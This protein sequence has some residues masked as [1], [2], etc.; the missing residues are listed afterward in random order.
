MIHSNRLARPLRLLI[1]TH[2][3][4]F[5]PDERANAGV[6]I[7]DVATALQQRGHQVT[8]LAPAAPQRVQKP[9]AVPV[10]RFAWWG[11]QEA[12]GSWGLNPL[13]IAR[14]GSFLY[15]GA[16]AA[17]RLM[18]KNNF[19]VILSC[20]V[21]PGGVLA[22][23]AARAHPT[24]FVTWSLGTDIYQAARKPLLGSVIR[25]ILADASARFADGID[26]AHQTAL[27]GGKECRFLPSASALGGATGTERAKA[28]TP[29]RLVFVGRLE[30][31]KGPD[32][33]IEGL[34]QLKPVHRAQITLTLVGDGSL[35]DELRRRIKNAHLTKTVRMHGNESNPLVLQALL[36]R[37]DWLLIPSRSDSIPLVF[38]EA[39]R[40]NLPIAAA[41][42]GDL[43]HLVTTYK[44]GVHFAPQNPDAIAAALREM[45]ALPMEQYRR[46]CQNTRRAARDFSLERTVVQLEKELIWCLKKNKV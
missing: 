15:F 34:A 42:V 24:P 13:A 26:L 8:I 33:L 43:K 28:H 16:R 17:R 44:V 36:R 21:F 31:V 6:F 29:L 27:L 22:R 20:W 2:N 10:V 30:P 46:L 37:A 11:A 3:V 23:S 19:D 41:E 7:A 5:S 38:S 9:L 32:L 12:M 39:M 35:E 40:Q 1:I 4:P 14:L 25:G 45:I 18:L